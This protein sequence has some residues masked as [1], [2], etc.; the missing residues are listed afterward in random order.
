MMA[1]R[2]QSKAQ[3]A[4]AAARVADVRVFCE[5]RRVPLRDGLIIAVHR[6]R[7]AQKR[8]ALVRPLH[9][10]FSFS[11]STCFTGKPIPAQSTAFTQDIAAEYQ[12]TFID[13]VPS[14]VKLQRVPAPFES[15]V[16]ILIAGSKRIFKK[17]QQEVGATR[18]LPAVSDF[19]EAQPFLKNATA[20]TPGP[21][22]VPITLQMSV[23]SSESALSCQMSRLSSTYFLRYESLRP[24]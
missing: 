20:T 8:N 4:D 23:E 16:G 24:L 6:R 15:A 17:K 9:A 18:R 13:A 2:L 12:Y 3:L 10:A 11:H 22:C 21:V 5:L 7:V 19:L 14:V 1:V